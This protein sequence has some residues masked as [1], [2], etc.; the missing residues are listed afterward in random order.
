MVADLI[1][2]MEE[3][4]V[5]IFDYKP[6]I[7][8]IHAK[9]KGIKNWEYDS[10]SETY[11]SLIYV[12]HEKVLEIEMDRLFTMVSDI[13]SVTRCKWDPFVNKTLTSLEEHQ[14]EDGTLNIVGFNG[15]VGFQWFRKSE[16]TCLI[17]YSTC[18]HPIHNATN[19][20]FTEYMIWLKRIGKEKTFF[21]FYG[22]RPFIK[23]EHLQ[24]AKYLEIYKPWN[25]ANCRKLVP[26][27]ELECRGCKVERYRRCPDKKCYE[28]QRE[29]A[30]TCEFC[31]VIL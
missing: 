19:F 17:I 29:G 30:E 12:K 9:Y 10:E 7:K 8:Q 22:I 14:M 21:V 16:N 2:K 18:T 23:F 6:Q 4:Q 5:K 20:S 28:A 26:A 25:C 1:K 15:T 11:K 13:S 3:E 27:K 31:G 24:K